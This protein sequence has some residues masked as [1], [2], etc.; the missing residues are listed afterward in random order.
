M[1]C[2]IKSVDRFS[3]LV[4]YERLTPSNVPLVLS[5]DRA[6]DDDLRHAVSVH[7][8]DVI[9]RRLR[10]AAEHHRLQHRLL[11]RE[12]PREHACLH[13]RH[14][15]PRHL[16]WHDGLGTSRRQKGLDQGMPP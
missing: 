4:T 9:W 1:G 6:P 5:S 15:R 13:H 14:H 10:R 7:S 8:P 16:R 3:Q 11:A 2:A 12:V